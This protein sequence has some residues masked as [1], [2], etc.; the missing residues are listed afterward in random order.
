MFPIELRPG[1]EFGDLQPPVPL[2]QPASERKKFEKNIRVTV[3]GLVHAA[4][5]RWKVH[6]F[7]RGVCEKRAFGTLNRS[8]ARHIFIIISIAYGTLGR[9]SADP[10]YWGNMG[11]SLSWG[12]VGV[13]S[14]H[15]IIIEGFSFFYDAA[16]SRSDHADNVS[17]AVRHCQSP[18]NSTPEEPNGGPARTRKS[19]EKMSTGVD[20][21]RMK[22]KT[23]G[24]GHS[25]ASL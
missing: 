14:L 17:P 5:L 25:P 7:R 3:F 4:E 23:Y 15:H 2:I 16:N 13:G 18:R 6:G 19:S 12:Y 10:T 8:V 9:F 11:M 24:Y 1:D 21:Q 20:A 22:W